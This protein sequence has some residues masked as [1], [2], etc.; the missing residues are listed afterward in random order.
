MFILREV[1]AARCGY[2]RTQRN[3]T[4]AK[5]LITKETA[6]RLIQRPQSFQRL[7]GLQAKALVSHGETRPHPEKTGREQR[8][9]AKEIIGA[10]KLVR[11]ARRAKRAA[12]GGAISPI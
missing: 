10:H 6:K 11:G 9:R 5:P 4:G 7:K 3:E 8:S 2:A 1:K 12:T